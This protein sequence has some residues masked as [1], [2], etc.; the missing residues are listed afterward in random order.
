MLE[1]GGFEKTKKILGVFAEGEFQDRDDRQAINAAGT[2]CMAA[3]DA[4]GYLQEC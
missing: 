1:E 3:L 4:E 2:G